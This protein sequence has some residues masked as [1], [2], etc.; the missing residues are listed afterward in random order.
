MVAKRQ[1]RIAAQL[2]QGLQVFRRVDRA[3]KKG[4]PPGF[5]HAPCGIAQGAQFWPVYR[6][7]GRRAATFAQF[8]KADL[9]PQPGSHRGPAVVCAG[10]AAVSGA[11][12]E[13][14]TFP[15]RANDA[16]GTV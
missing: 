7:T 11:R 1:A 15:V 5:Q 13:N 4:T 9:R 14:V 16:V 10:L 3:F 2:R 6:V 8:Q 12:S